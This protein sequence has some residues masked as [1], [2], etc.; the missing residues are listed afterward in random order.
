MPRKFWGID[1]VWNQDFWRRWAD[2]APELRSSNGMLLM[3]GGMPKEGRCLGCGPE[4]GRVS[5]NA[6]RLSPIS[7]DRRETPAAAITSYFFADSERSGVNKT[8]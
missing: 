1:S 8:A 2:P 4:V 3:S 5:H 6:K 7:E